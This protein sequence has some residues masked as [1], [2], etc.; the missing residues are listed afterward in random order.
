MPPI[1][2]RIYREKDGAA[3]LVRRLRELPNRARTKCYLRMQRLAAQGHE[4]RRPEA[5]I[6]RD[7]IHELRVA[8]Q[9]VQYRMLYFFHGQVAVVVSHGIIKRGDRV[10]EN[11]IDVAI[12]RRRAFQSDPDGHTFEGALPWEN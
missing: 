3:P 5:D 12:A 9:G 10:P 2:L 7:G 4:L 1:A 11:E 6:L 8:L